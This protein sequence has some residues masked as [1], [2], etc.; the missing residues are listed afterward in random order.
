LDVVF[1]RTAPVPEPPAVPRALLALL[2]IAAS[3]AGQDKAKS[4]DLITVK[5]GT[6]PVI[7]SAPHGGRKPIP[8]CPERKGGPHVKLFAVVTDTNSD[9]LAEKV[10]GAIEKKMNGKPDLVIARFERK[11]LDVNRP[12]ADAYES[13]AA[14]PVYEAYHKALKDA[15]DA[16]QKEWGRGLFLD[17]H[18]QA[19]YPNLVLRGTN[20]G[21][22][23]AH[24]VDRFGKAAVTGPEGILGRLAAGGYKVF[25]AN[26]SDDKENPFFSG[27]YIVQTYGSKHGGSVDAI[28]LEFGSKLRMR[29]NLD[30]TA[31]AVADAVTVFSRAY[32]PAAKVKKK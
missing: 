3:A 13:E 11:Y 27:G 23:V 24:L 14:K 6:L 22:T 16:V 18:G 19:A 8:D 21:K 17:L 4:D 28:Q 10:A 7:V 29:V 26:D 30:A 1:L 15:R 20:N 12:A 31:D 9:L 2:F 32:L 5:A 25:P